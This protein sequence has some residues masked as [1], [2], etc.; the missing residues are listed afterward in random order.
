MAG[1]CGYNNNNKRSLLQLRQLSNTGA[2]GSLAK[3]LRITNSRR[4][5]PFIGHRYKCSSCPGLSVRPAF[6]TFASPKIS[7]HSPCSDSDCDVGWPTNLSKL[8]G[9]LGAGCLCRSLSLCLCLCLYP[10]ISLCA[11]FPLPFSL[12]QCLAI[13]FSH[14]WQVFCLIT[15]SCLQCVQKIPDFDSCLALPGSVCGSLRASGCG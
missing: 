1:S 6:V 4:L 10:V 7:S 3:I 2:H 11:L 9:S 12:S 13:Y 5:I 14:L 15:L 8:L